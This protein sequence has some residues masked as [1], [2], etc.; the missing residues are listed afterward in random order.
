MFKGDTHDAR[1]SIASA[2]RRPPGSASRP[3]RHTYLSGAL[4][5]V[6]KAPDEPNPED[7]GKPPP[8]PPSDELDDEIAAFFAKVKSSWKQVRTA[9]KLGWAKKRIAASDGAIMSRILMSE[10]REAAPWN[11]TNLVLESNSLGDSGLATLSWALS[12]GALRSLTRLN[13]TFNKIGQAGVVA[14]A[15]SLRSGA[16]PQ[17]EWLFLNGNLIDD[18][19]ITAFAS[20]LEG[21]QGSP[22]RGATP[23]DGTWIGVPALPKLTQLW[24]HENQIGDAGVAALLKP[25]ANGAALP[26]LGTLSLDHNQIRR[27]GVAAIA[28]A[29]AAGALPKCKNLLLNDNPAGP[30]AQQQVADA[31]ARRK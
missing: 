9:T 10:T 3:P 4:D 20:A 15:T 18:A 22:S 30:R 28:A 11:L 25:L 2:P 24:L 27:D 19:G 29:V 12:K 23:G 21:T 1:H 7:E 17:L 16:L 14:L 13:L 26:N 8:P 6:T 31:I 5:Y